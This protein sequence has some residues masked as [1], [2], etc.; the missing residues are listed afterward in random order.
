MRRLANAGDESA[1]F[2]YQ[3]NFFEGHAGVEADVDEGLAWLRKAAN[4]LE[5][6]QGSP[7]VDYAKKIADYTKAIRLDPKDATAY[8]NRG[9]LWEAKGDYDKAIADYNEALQLDPKYAYAYNSRGNVWKAKGD[10]DKAIADYNK[11]LRLDPKYVYAYNNRGTVWKAKGN[12]DKAIADYNDALRL[13]P[14]DAYA[15]NSR[16]NVWKAK[17]NYDNA[18]ADYNEALRLDPEYANAHNALAWLRATCTDAKYRDGKQAV[19]DATKAC[20]LTGW[21]VAN[22][23]DTLAA[24]C[25]E[26]EDFEKA[27]EWQTKAVGIVPESRKASYKKSLDLY[28]AGKPYRE[29]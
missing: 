13:D 26:A 3:Q 9:N 1:Q 11:A 24:A 27:V 12:Y 20:E 4:W 15:Y 7:P 29:E 23:I 16:G 25:A 21:K 19:A 28:R 2:A 17:G 5:R 14:K 6:G 18:I 8:Y 22:N 10:Y